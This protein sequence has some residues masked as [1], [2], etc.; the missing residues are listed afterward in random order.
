VCPNSETGRCLMPIINELLA[1]STVGE[2]LNAHSDL[3]FAY[4]SAWLEKNRGAGMEDARLRFRS[5]R[6]VPCTR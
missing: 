6:I 5:S 4:R 3:F 2:L 1:T